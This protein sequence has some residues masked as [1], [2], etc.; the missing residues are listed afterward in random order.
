MA[1]FADINVSQGS[2]AA[3]AR[4]GGIC[5]IHLTT[6]LLRNLPVKKW[7]KSVMVRQNYGHASVALFFCPPCTVLADV[8]VIS[9]WSVTRT[10]LQGMQT[11]AD[12]GSNTRSKY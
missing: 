12:Y 5:Y 10:N 3:Y 8:T 2:V 6:N 11:L 4:C 9:G 1:C 7:L